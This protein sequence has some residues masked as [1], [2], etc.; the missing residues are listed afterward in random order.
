MMMAGAGGSAGFDLL[1]V[2]L[3]LGVELQIPLEFIVCLP[4]GL[5]Q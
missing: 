3:S 4:A 1:F 2:P 5:F